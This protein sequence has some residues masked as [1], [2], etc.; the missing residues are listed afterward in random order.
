LRTCR[1]GPVGF[2]NVASIQY[3]T[4]LPDQLTRRST[5]IHAARN[6]LT[7]VLQVLQEDRDRVRLPRSM[8]RA[9]LAEVHDWVGETLLDHGQV[10]EARKHILESLRHWPLQPR[11]LTLL[12]R[13]SMPKN[14]GSFLRHCWRWLK[15][16]ALPNW[17]NRPKTDIDSQRKADFS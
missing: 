2:V 4:G 3:Q 16:S 8:I 11:A 7:T 9:R 13:S 1:E 5:R 15:T 12:V 17:A 10:A 14:V 6:C